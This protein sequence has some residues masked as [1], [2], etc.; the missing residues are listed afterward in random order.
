M[1]RTRN[2]CALNSDERWKVLKRSPRRTHLRKDQASLSSPSN[3]NADVLAL[4]GPLPILDVVA[5]SSCLAYLRPR[6][7]GSPW[8]LSAKRNRRKR[9]R[10]HRQLGDDTVSAECRVWQTCRVSLESGSGF[11]KRKKRL[12]SASIHPHR[13]R[14]PL[15]HGHGRKPRRAPRPDKRKLS[16]TPPMLGWLSPRKAPANAARHISSSSGTSLVSSANKPRATP[17][18]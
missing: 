14:R 12:S 9:G 4:A 18:T 10:N 17:T 6:S 1:R 11:G 7:E 3:I 5:K 8:L 13:C 16:P 15:P 2:V